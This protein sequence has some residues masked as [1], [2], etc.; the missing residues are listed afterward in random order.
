MVVFLGLENIEMKRSKHR[1]IATE[2]CQ[3]FDEFNK[4][5]VFYDS[6]TCSETEN[7]QKSLCSV[8]ISNIL[9]FALQFYGKFDIFH[10]YN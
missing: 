8:S 3:D 5:S 1:L 4:L 9:I 6:F 10:F 2:K 7:Y